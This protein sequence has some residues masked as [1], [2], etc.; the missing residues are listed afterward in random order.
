MSRLFAS[1]GQSFG[2]SALASVFLLNIQGC[3]P[4]GLTGLISLESK[5]TLKSLYSNKKFNQKFY[6]IRREMVLSVNSSSDLNFIEA[7]TWVSPY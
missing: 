4:L 7:R 5:D 3:F 6:T 1:C 2:A